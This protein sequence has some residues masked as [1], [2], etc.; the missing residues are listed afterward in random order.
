MTQDANFTRLFLRNDV[1]K[2][3]RFPLGRFSVV[4][5]DGRVGVGKSVAEALDKA[6]TDNPGAAIAALR[7]A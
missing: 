1:V 4:L 5:Q 6:K 7:A 3:E 2:I